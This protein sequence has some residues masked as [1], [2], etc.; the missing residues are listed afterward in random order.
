[1][2][3]LICLVLALCVCLPL[4]AADEDGERWQLIRE[5]LFGDRAIE[6]GDHLMAL[7][8]PF[9]ASDAAL[10]PIGVEDQ[11]DEADPAIRRLWLI[12][13]DNPVPLAGSFEYG[14]AASSIDMS[15][16]VRVN[17]YSHVRAV[18][19]TEDGSLYMV[20]EHVRASGGCSAPVSADDEE[21][22]KGMGEIRVRA[23]D[24][25]DKGGADLQISIRHPNFS[26]MQMDQVTRLYRRAHYVKDVE[27]LS[28]GERVLRADL[29]IAMSR[30]PSLRLASSMAGDQ[31]VT[32][33]VNDSEGNTFREEVSVSPRI[34]DFDFSA[35][36]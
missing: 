33:V 18:A 25:Q 17:A 21:A 36:Q 28:G 6:K 1:M 14:P 3:R 32:V 10:V 27:V 23:W 30:D 11:R 13:D 20:R 31:D 12:V 26:G 9:R 2:S 24:R 34:S 7:K 22:L 19:E 29:T 4:W 8:A 15:T 16:R 5:D 35:V